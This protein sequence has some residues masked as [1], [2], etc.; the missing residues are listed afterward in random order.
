MGVPDKM[1]GLAFW[2]Q[3]KA[4]EEDAKARELERLRQMEIEQCVKS[5]R[6][7]LEAYV[8]LGPNSKTEVKAQAKAAKEAEAKAAKEA[9]AKAAK[10]AKAKAAKEAKAKAAQII[11][12]A[13]ER[14]RRIQLKRLARK[15][16]EELEAYVELGPNSKTEVKAH[17]ND[18][19]EVYF[20]C[21]TF[22]KLD[23]C[24]KLHI[25][26]EFDLLLLGEG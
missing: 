6:D 19:W 15:W 4:A 18:P 21:Q 17:T 22:G 26:L 25:D 10:E 16:R 3:A 9:E 8:K 2:A 13:M 20:E 7:E 12:T 11:A 5:W 14:Y 23:F 1:M 24:D